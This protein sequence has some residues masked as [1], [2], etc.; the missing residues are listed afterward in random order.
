MKVCAEQL[1]GLKAAL[2]EEDWLKV[3]MAYEP[4]WAIG[5]SD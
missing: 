4:V 2:K 5:Q 1:E 3:V